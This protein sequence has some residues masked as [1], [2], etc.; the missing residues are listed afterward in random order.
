[1]QTAEQT[2]GRQMCLETEKAPAVC[3]FFKLGHSEHMHHN[4]SLNSGIIITTTT[5][6]SQY[7]PSYNT[8]PLRTPQPFGALPHPKA[9]GHQ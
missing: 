5:E 7:H 9:R 3:P 4:N 1:M 8:S 6:A 2:E